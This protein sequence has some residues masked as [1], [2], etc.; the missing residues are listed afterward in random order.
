VLSQHL[1]LFGDYILHAGLCSNGV[2]HQ[3]LALLQVYNPPKIM[4]ERKINKLAG[5][6]MVSA[7]TLLSLMSEMAGTNR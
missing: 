5:L 6:A 3:A 7:V 1:Y 2:N 4:G